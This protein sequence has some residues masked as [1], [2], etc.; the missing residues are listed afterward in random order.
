MFVPMRGRS[1]RDR[2]ARKSLRKLVELGLAV[3][4]GIAGVVNMPASERAKL[5]SERGQGRMRYRL[6]L[7]AKHEQD[8]ARIQAGEPGAEVTLP[9]GNGAYRLML[10]DG[11]QSYREIVR[12]SGLLKIGDRLGIRR[13]HDDILD[14][15]FGWFSLIGILSVPASR[16]ITANSKGQRVEPDGMLYCSSPVGIGP[17]FFELELSHLGPAEVRV[18]I[19][20]YSLLRTSYP[21]A[22]ICGTDLGARHFDKIGQ[23]L[24]VPVVATSLARLRKVGLEGRAWI[25]RGQEVCVTAV[26][27]PPAPAGH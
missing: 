13:N 6:S 5:F 25:Y 21:L 14:D 12:R 17:H 7:S 22:V 26:R 23:E 3:D 19:K 2:T 15:L 9:T 24:G 4:A 1:D 18:R 16:A 11:G 20:R 10:D 27:C 8:L